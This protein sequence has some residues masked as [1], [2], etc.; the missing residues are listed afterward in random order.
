MM[1]AE[2]CPPV[3]A[4]PP[5]HLFFG[6]SLRGPPSPVQDCNPAVSPLSGAVAFA[7]QSLLR[8]VPSPILETFPT[9]TL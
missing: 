8:Q 1:A 9:A 6:F 3:S 7:F 4:S 2:F 5:S